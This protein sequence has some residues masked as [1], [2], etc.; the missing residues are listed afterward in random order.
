MKLS[1]ARDA[2]Y[3]H[4]GNASTCARQ[5]AFAGV[6]VVWI[7]N[8]KIPNQ[9][10]SLPRVLTIVVLAL[11]ATLA[12]DLLQYILASLMWGAFARGHEKN[13][14]SHRRHDDPDVDVPAWINWPA[15]F[16]FWLKLVSLVVAYGLLAS[17]LWRLAW[18]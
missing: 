12:F 13:S 16:C 3:T 11:V 15:L 2:Y 5:L 1:E 6:A 9:P 17:Y 10:I 14:E 8:D 4:S 18:R 7:F